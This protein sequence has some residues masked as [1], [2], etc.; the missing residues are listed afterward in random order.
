MKIQKNKTSAKNALGQIMRGSLSISDY[1]QPFIE[2][3]INDDLNVWTHIDE[4]E[5]QQQVE[6]LSANLQSKFEENLAV[7]RASH[8]KKSDSE[9]IDPSAKLL[10]LPVAIKDIID[11]AGIE[12][13]CGSRIYQG[14]EA[15]LHHKK[16][17]DASVVSRLRAAGGILMGKTVTTE[18]ATFQAADTKNPAALGRTP[19]GSSSGSAAAVAA[20]MAPLALGTQTAGSIVR[21]ASYCGVVGFKPTIGTLDL[22]GVKALARSFDTLGVFAGCVEDAA[23]LMDSLTG[24]HWLVQC[25]EDN[26][27]RKVGLCRSPYWSAASDDL[28]KVWED[29]VYLLKSMDGVIVDEFHLPPEFGGAVELHKRVLAR[30]AFDA[31]HFEWKTYRSLIRSK[32]AII[33]EEGEASKTECYLADIQKIGSL[34]REFDRA[35]CDFD[36]LITPSSPGVPPPIEEGTGDPIFNRLWSMLGVPAMNVPG[37][38]GEKGWPIGIQVVSRQGEDAKVIAASFWLEN[39]LNAT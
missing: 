31:L 21:P 17:I 6:Y 9:R 16:A 1:C 5:I 39:I 18:F 13:G 2:K 19:G 28:C 11:I 34:R 14:F 7:S 10:G 32:L 30:E 25:R 8:Q 26:Q 35:L 38:Q 12:T 22:S 37:L 4:G 29:L 24:N 27:P 20:G 33:L 36:V 3:S 15:P 23:F